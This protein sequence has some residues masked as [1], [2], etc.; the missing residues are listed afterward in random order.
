MDTS[1]RLL[2]PFRYDK[3]ETNMISNH[4]LLALLA[5]TK[6][7]VVTP[8]YAGVPM[9]PATRTA[10]Y[11]T[12]TTLPIHNPLNERGVVELGGGDTQVDATRTRALVEKGCRLG[13]LALTVSTLAGCAQP[14]RAPVTPPPS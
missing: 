4:K 5:I 6:D 1:Q 10:D 2:S 3:V 13:L 7:S 9:Q 8:Q 11:A 14:S 12:S